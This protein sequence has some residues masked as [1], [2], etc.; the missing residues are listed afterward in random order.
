MSEVVS[1]TVML[2]L[3]LTIAGKFLFDASWAAVGLNMKL[4]GISLELL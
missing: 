3:T 1:L 2:A 4:T